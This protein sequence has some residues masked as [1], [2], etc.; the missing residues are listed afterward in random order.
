MNIKCCFILFQVNGL[1]NHSYVS[2]NLLNK[3]KSYIYSMHEE[4]R[5]R[6]HTVSSE[7]CRGGNINKTISWS[8]SNQVLQM[9]EE[10]REYTEITEKLHENYQE[11]NSTKSKGMKNNAKSAHK[12]AQLTVNSSMTT[13]QNEAKQQLTLHSLQDLLIWFDSIWFYS[14]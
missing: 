10:L 5:F 6:Y 3:L 9:V 7:V 2:S 13:H 12:K 4:F 11:P 14:V 1:A 8:K